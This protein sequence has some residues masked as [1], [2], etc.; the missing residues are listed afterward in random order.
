MD[1][2]T[3]NMFWRICF[4]FLASFIAAGNILI[5]CIF[6]KLR[7]RKRSSF[8][9]I[10]LGVADLLVGGLAIP[11]FIA[12][13]ETSSL[14]T[15]FVFERV[16]MFTGTSSI[17]TL[18]VISLER[19][20]AIG[21]PLSHRTLNFR[22]YICAIVIP[23]IIAVIF[24]ILM[25]AGSILDSDSVICL[26]VLF[27]TTPLLVMSVAYYVIWK[28]QKSRM[29]NHN[30]VIREVKLANT[31]FIITGAS[32]L[33]WL[34]FQ[35]LNLSASLHMNANIPHMQ[36]MTLIVKALQYSNSFV[37]VI[38]Y[39][40]R[41][42]EFKNCLLHLLRCCVVPSQVFNS[43]LSPLTES[44]SVVS[45]VRFT[46]TQLL[47]PISRQESA[48]W[49]LYC[50]NSSLNNFLLP[51]SDRIE[52]K[53]CLWYQTCAERLDILLKLPRVHC[54]SLSSFRL[55]MKFRLF[56]GSQT[57]SRLCL[58]AE[59]N[60]ESENGEFRVLHISWDEWS[61]G[62]RSLFHANSSSQSQY[63][64]PRDEYNKKSEIFYPLVD[65]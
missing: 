50:W 58:K 22:V 29:V 15:V 45:L 26:L 41:I 2:N 49:L 60:Q 30:H 61:W 17:Y 11:L 18:A 31:L 33:T 10:G 57:S 4:G 1:F 48:V 63:D 47:S 34:P 21:W 38:I 59:V 54:E 36:L 51:L 25:Y 43:G 35:I 37:N 64:K 28:K 56:K 9:L 62:W 12:G 6:F 23:W 39:P 46:S 19:M 55:S 32:L 65:H 5:I 16:D 44:G 7:R 20:F 13:Y 53:S 24:T 8:L 27:P 3:W 40:L 14:K 52:G 42:P